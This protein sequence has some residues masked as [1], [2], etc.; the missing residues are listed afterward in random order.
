MKRGPSLR[1]GGLLALTLALLAVAGC[2]GAPAPT[3]TAA[4][5]PT[6]GPGVAGATPV[7]AVTPVTPITTA[8]A[9]ATL[10]AVATTPAT[11]ATAA[12]TTP[13]ATTTVVLATSSTHGSYLATPSGLPLYT[14]SGDS[15]GTSTVTGTRLAN[16]PAFTATGSL[17]LPPG[18]PGTLSEI[19]RPDGSKQV[20]YNQMPLYTFVK[21][22]PGQVNGQGV[23]GFQL[24]TVS[25]SGTPGATG[26][27]APAV[28][29]TPTP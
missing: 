27:S 2:A 21:D 7:P 24:A 8:T 12:T 16:W 9:P 18:V 5:A 4:P 28:G 22:S 13:G 23:A 17:T 29:A 14:F 19:T 6:T 25:A 1:A 26:T 10:T 20:A 3:P 15:P 11:T